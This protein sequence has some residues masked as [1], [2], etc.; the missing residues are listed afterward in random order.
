[1]CDNTLRN[2]LFVDFLQIIYPVIFA[3]FLVANTLFIS[4]EFARMRMRN[5]TFVALKSLIMKLTVSCWYF[6]IYLS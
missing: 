2:S 5:T 4:D 6:L 3:G 1:M